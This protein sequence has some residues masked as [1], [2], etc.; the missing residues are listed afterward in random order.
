MI[1][2]KKVQAKCCQAFTVNLKRPKELQF[3]SL[4]E[5]TVT[6]TF[7]MGRMA[8]LRPIKPCPG[9]LDEYEAICGCDLSPWAV[10]VVRMDR[11]HLLVT[12]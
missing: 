11:G 4:V 10:S 2:A 3:T 9:H 5:K 1:V 8:P 12:G 7:N 6:K